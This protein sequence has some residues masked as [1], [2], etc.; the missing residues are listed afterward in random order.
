MA[1]LQCGGCER[2][3]SVSMV[4]GGNPV[5]LADPERWSTT[6]RV[7]EG[8]KRSF[9]DR[10]AAAARC[11]ACST[12]FAPAARAARPAGAGARRTG[13]Q[14]SETAA[15]TG[16]RSWITTAAILG[17][18]WF[19]VRMQKMD[20][21]AQA[22][23]YLACVAV[24]VWGSWRLLTA[25]QVQMGVRYLALALMLVPGLNVL[26]LL[27]LRFFAD[28]LI[29]E[30]ALS[31]AGM[32]SEPDDS[33]PP[34]RSARPATPAAAPAPPPEPQARDPLQIAGEMLGLVSGATVRSFHTVDFGREK[35]PGTFSVLVP[36]SAARHLVARL[37]ARFP[38]GLIVFMGSSRFLDDPAVQ[39]MVELVVARGDSQF[40][41]LRLAQTEPVNHGLSTGDV[42][43][44]LQKYD[45]SFGVEVFQ[46][47]TDSV[48]FKLGKLPGNLRAFCNDLHL[49]CPD[50]VEAGGEEMYAAGLAESGGWVG[51]WW[52]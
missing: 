43:N 29:K 30:A 7:C 34:S 27:G 3:I 42:I 44:R 8:C 48:L 1:V 26:A 19:L 31:A 40:D 49:F 22:T 16:A 2:F 50:T 25:A 45:R 11:P 20:I 36:E 37:R 52:D 28:R 35:K 15:L 10:C 6:R 39:G 13:R 9:C 32:D 12:P 38:A 17:A 51:L 18:V 4:A 14:H 47:E 23:L 5:A 33:V 46:A 41:A 24:G 21:G